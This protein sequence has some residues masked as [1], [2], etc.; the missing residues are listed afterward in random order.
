MMTTRY[1]SRDMNVTVFVDAAGIT[2]TNDAETIAEKSA[3]V[4]DPSDCFAI[5]QDKELWETLRNLL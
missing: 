1:T 2:I 4:D 5:F 3:V